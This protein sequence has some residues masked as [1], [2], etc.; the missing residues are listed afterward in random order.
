[1]NTTR[2]QPTELLLVDA[3]TAA[4]LLSISERQLWAL[5]K[6]GQIACVRVGKRG[7][8]YDP[9]DLRDFVTNSKHGA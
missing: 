9:V 8:R 5:T 2:A 4:G 1:M 7:I 6:D 3:R